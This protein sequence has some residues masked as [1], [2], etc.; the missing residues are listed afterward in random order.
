MDKQRRGYVQIPRAALD[1]ATQK[2]P[3]ICAAVIDLY[4]L[5]DRRRW[6]PFDAS[7]RFVAARWGLSKGRAERVVRDLRGLELVTI[8]PGSRDSPRRLIVHR[9]ADHLLD[10][11][12]DHLPDHPVDH[13]HRSTAPPSDIETDH[14]VDHLPDHPVDHPMDQ[15][16]RTILEPSR[17]TP[18]EAPQGASSQPDAVGRLWDALSAI[19]SE[20]RPKARGLALTAHRRRT[21]KA[22]LKDYDEER[23]LSAYRWWWT[24]TSETQ[25]QLRENY[26]LDTFLRPSRHDR[27]QAEAARAEEEPEPWKYQP[28][29][30]EEVQRAR[31]AE[32]AYRDELDKQR[33]AIAAEMRAAGTE[34][35]I[36]YTDLERYERAK[37][38]IINGGTLPSHAAAERARDDILNPCPF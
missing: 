38:G 35:P 9:G 23:I 37:H 6:E 14:P 18:L 29:S 3:E 12:P 27:Y 1:Y 20:Y 33:R 16:I 4:L 36:H 26:D 28:P 31:E 5:A 8:Q 22:R 7:Q 10:H 13:L 30:E 21:L 34:G 24:D 11:L 25:S 15:S 19:R 17:T 2:A 32:S